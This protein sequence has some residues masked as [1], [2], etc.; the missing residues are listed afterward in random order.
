LQF[1]AFP[2]IDGDVIEAR[3]LLPQGTPLARTEAVAGE[4]VAALERVDKEFTPR[5]PGGQHLVKHT[6]IHFNRNLDAH[7]VGPHVATVTADLLTAERRVGRL[8]EVFSR[9]REETGELPDV[10][11][12]SF[13]EPQIGPAGQP[14]EIRLRGSDLTG[15]KA[16]SLELQAW[17]RDYVGVFDLLDDLR[18]GRPELRLR[19]QEGALALGLDAATVAQQ[20]RAAFLG[21]TAKEIQIGRE[22][23]EIDVR[24]SQIDRN[25]LAELEDFRITTPERQQVPLMA[26]AALEAERGYARIHRI[27]GR[28]TVTVQGEVDTRL[29]NAN[30]ILSD[31]QEQFLPKLQERYPTIQI[32]LEGQEREAQTAGASLRR[33]F[34][35]GLIGIFILLSFQFRSYIEPVVVMAIIP[36]ALIGVVVGHLLMGLDLSMPSMMGFVSLTGIVVNDSILLVTFLK[37]R[38]QEG[39]AVMDAARLASRERFRAVLLTSL[40]TI[41]GL[42][43]LLAERSL[44]AQVL[45]PLVTS[46]IFG[47]LAT[48][49]LVLLVVPALYS[50]LHDWGYTALA[51]ERGS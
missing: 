11:S 36:L 19:L 25:N 40:T 31:T 35:I 37:L 29:A 42:L 43:P 51:R 34:L 5:Q 10:L 47:L 1:R 33:G 8:E 20:L 24:L 39:L 46:I 14:I 4:V 48:T 30:A 6:G 17:L 26:V 41:A 49:M 16:A 13:K 2:E 15:L 38:V 28:R 27:D 9:W 22:D 7:E 23:Y 50:I 45:I 3:I 18:P 44:Q 32:T 21:V 12:I